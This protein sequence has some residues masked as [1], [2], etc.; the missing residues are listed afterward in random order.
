[1]RKEEI[2]IGDNYFQSSVCKMMTLAT[3]TSKLACIHHLQN[4]RSIPL[5]LSNT[6]SRMPRGKGA[7]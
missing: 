1:M 2:E 5:S 6:I 4:N 7:S 3:A